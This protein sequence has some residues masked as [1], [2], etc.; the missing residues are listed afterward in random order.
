MIGGNG[1]K[2][3]ELAPRTFSAIGMGAIALWTTYTGGWPFM[4]LIW[5]GA[6]V[7]CW[8]W[9]NIVRDGAG[10]D[11]TFFIHIATLLLVSVHPGLLLLGD[12]LP[13]FPWPETAVFWTI[14]IIMFLMSLS[15]IV[16]AVIVYFTAKEKTW[17]AFGIVY[18]S[19]AVASL[20]IIRSDHLSTTEVPW[21]IWAILYIFAIVWATDIAAYFA[22]RAIGGPKLWP[23]ISPKKTWAGLLGGVLAAGLV[24]GIFAELTPVDGTTQLIAVGMILAVI[25]QLGDLLISVMKRRFDTKDASNL[26]PGHGG[27]LDRVDGL[28][29]VAIAV[30]ALGMTKGDTFARAL[31]LW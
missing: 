16:G 13:G 21:G 8:E 29:L 19:F 12:T 3:S 26:I 20:I 6:V 23:R 27:L 22:G 11:R 31:L 15:P 1:N 14:V 30:F 2:W 4:L 9:S 10:F 7:L 18:I 24:S 25:A 5:A 28:L 17:S